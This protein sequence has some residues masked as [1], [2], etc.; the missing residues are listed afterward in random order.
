MDGADL[1]VAVNSDPRAPIFTAAHYGTT[2]DL[3]DLL[4]AV[5]ERLREGV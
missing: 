1:I 5:A 3:F 2:C 4:P